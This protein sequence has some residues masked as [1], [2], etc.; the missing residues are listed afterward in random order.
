MT[1]VFRSRPSR[2]RDASDANS[3]HA[4]GG[5][6]EF[7]SYAWNTRDNSKDTKIGFQA[8]VIGSQ[9]SHLT[10]FLATG[11]KILNI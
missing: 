5:W 11:K 1:P 9:G 6:E 7:V 3:S 2:A 4:P 10:K 8:D